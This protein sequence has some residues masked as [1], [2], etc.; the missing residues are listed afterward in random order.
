MN[1]TRYSGALALTLLLAA[2]GKEP[3]PTPEGQDAAS[4]GPTSTAAA[5]VYSGT[6]TIQSIS[7]DQVTI[8]HGPIDGIGWPAMTMPFTA[9]PGMAEKVQAGSLVDFSFR[10]HGG[11]YQL[12]ALRPR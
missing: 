8:A 1:S 12:T 3:T 11:A 10:Q 5:E 4:G 9:S 7:G 6:G 2:C